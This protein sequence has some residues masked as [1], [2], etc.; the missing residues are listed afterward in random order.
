MKKKMLLVMILC[1]FLGGIVY[2]E[3]IDTE[4]PPPKNTVSIDI[5][6]IG[7]SLLLTGVYNISGLSSMYSATGIQYERQLS[8]YV[9]LATLLGYTGIFFFDSGSN[10]S[11]FSVEEHIR[12]YPQ[13]DTFFLDGMLGY[14]NMITQFNGKEPIL[15]HYFTVGGKLGWRIDFDK[16]GGLIFEPS[17]GYYGAFGKTNVSIELSGDNFWVNFLSFFQHALMDVVAKYA[18]VGGPRFSL[19][20]GYR[21]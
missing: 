15:S 6:A 2:A 16:P 1:I 5:G 3:E 17:F 10:I 14:G 12:Y 4:N 18:L 11:S 20:L 19:C 9:S 7:Y 21:F 13:R 8:E